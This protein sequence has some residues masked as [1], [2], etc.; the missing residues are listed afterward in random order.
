MGVTESRA[1]GPGRA[2]SRGVG[3]PEGNRGLRS[4]ATQLSWLAVICLF[5]LGACTARPHY[6]VVEYD[7]AHRPEVA[8]TT[9]APEV[10]GGVA[11]TRCDTAMC[12][13]LAKHVEDAASARGY[14]FDPDG[15]L[16]LH[17]DD[18]TLGGAAAIL[19]DVP[20]VRYVFQTAPDKREQVA[21]ERDADKVEARCRGRFYAFLDQ[22]EE[23]RSV[24]RTRAVLRRGDETLWD[25][26]RVHGDAA[27][28]EGDPRFIYRAGD[29]FILFGRRRA[30]AK[31]R[32][33]DAVCTDRRVEYPLL[34]AGRSG[35]GTPVRREVILFARSVE[36]EAPNID[37]WLQEA[38]EELVSAL[39]TPAESAPPPAA[40]SGPA[41]TPLD[42]LDPAPGTDGPSPD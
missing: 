36:H 29:N 28:I 22:T 13:R 24:A 15:A 8:A 20:K 34:G 9:G 19:Y 26:R 12:E 23:I 25:V 35:F 31:A 14:A 21:L 5:G 1:E 40:D 7:V 37:G 11:L 10:T 32:V 2:G 17:I 33:H 6:Y 3:R 38:A 30:L 27:L 42:A 18:V 4:G 41:A 39:V 16:T